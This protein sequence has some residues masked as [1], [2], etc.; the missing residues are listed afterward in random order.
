[1][2]DKILDVRHVMDEMVSPEGL[3]AGGGGGGA[4][5]DDFVAGA[6]IEIMPDFLT[7]SKIQISVDPKIVEVGDTFYANIDIPDDL[8]ENHSDLVLSSDRPSLYYGGTVAADEAAFYDDNGNTFT[9]AELRSYMMTHA[10]K[11]IQVTL[12]DYN[13]KK[14]VIEAK[15]N[16]NSGRMFNGTEL[17]TGPDLVTN[18]QTI[19]IG[20]NAYK[21]MPIY[22]A[23]FTYDQINQTVDWAIHGQ[24]EAADSLI[25]SV[26][27]TQSISTGETVIG[28]I[29]TLIEAVTPTGCILPFGGSTAPSGYLLCD[30]TEVSRTTYAE[31]YSVIG[32]SFKGNK[33][34][35]SGN[36]CLPDLRECT[37][38]GASD[39]NNDTYTIETHQKI[40][41]GEFLDDRVQ[42]HTHTMDGTWQINSEASGSPIV[43]YGTNV[44]GTIGTD[45]STSNP[46]GRSSNTTEVKSVGVNYIIKA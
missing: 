17:G 44:Y 4:S 34:P 12:R 27:G 7:E 18:D 35:T 3:Q 10:M 19:T 46:S 45:Y 38:K 21:A 25:G 43:S 6:G 39:T 20:G 40:A 9:P 31:L 14:I 30:G 15:Y 26:I 29:N 36:F 1:M 24:L 11:S 2:A 32:D 33:T 37:L 8:H 22:Y 13:Y 42:E 28:A 23:S 5:I 16:S 41:L